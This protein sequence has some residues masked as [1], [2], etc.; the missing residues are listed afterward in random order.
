MICD[1]PRGRW[2]NQPWNLIWNMFLEPGCEAFRTRWHCR[3]LRECLN[4]FMQALLLGI[5]VL[6]KHKNET[7]WICLYKCMYRVCELLSASKVLHLFYK[8]DFD[9]SA[10]TKWGIS[11]SSLFLPFALSVFSSK[12]PPGGQILQMPGFSRAWRWSRVWLQK[13]CGFSGATHKYQLVQFLLVQ[14]PAGAG[15]ASFFGD[16]F[17]SLI[18]TLSVPKSPFWGSHTH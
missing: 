2:V 15:K 18:R 1:R 14:H 17:V 11:C 6:L 10:L 12:T 7:A 8:A 5:V 16:L 13:Y 3:A 4:F 9:S